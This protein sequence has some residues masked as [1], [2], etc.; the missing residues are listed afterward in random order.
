MAENLY[1]LARGIHYD[2]TVF[3]ML[4]VALKSRTSSGSSSPSMYSEILSTICRHRIAGILSEI[5]GQFLAPLQ[6]R[7]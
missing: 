1:G 4:Q 6:S 5:L 3:T 7:A 2:A